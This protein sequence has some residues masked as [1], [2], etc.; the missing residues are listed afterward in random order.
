MGSC[1]TNMQSALPQKELCAHLA[2]SHVDGVEEIFAP[3]GVGDV[4]DVSQRVVQR[5]LLGADYHLVDKYF[6]FKKCFHGI[7]TICAGQNDSKCLEP[8]MFPVDTEFISR[9]SLNGLPACLIQ[10]RHRV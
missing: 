5:P 10:T 1:S 8:A 7:K 2:D 3:D 4:A 9:P 6:F